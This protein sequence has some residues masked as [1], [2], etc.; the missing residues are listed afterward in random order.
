M[1]TPL[2][3]NL[4]PVQVGFNKKYE[5]KKDGNNLPTPAYYDQVPAP[6]QELQKS[7]IQEMK[8][9]DVGLMEEVR[10]RINEK[11]PEPYY[12]PTEFG[13]IPVSY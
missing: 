11:T 6:P 8:Q 12:D 1:E 3:R 4:G 10:P 2:Y 7:G 5:V 13:V 9:N